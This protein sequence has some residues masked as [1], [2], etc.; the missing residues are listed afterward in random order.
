MVER[1]EGTPSL[2]TES[3][4]GIDKDAIISRAAD[5]AAEEAK[6]Q[7][8][9]S[10]GEIKGRLEDANEKIK[11]ANDLMRPFSKYERLGRKAVRK[12]G[13]NMPRTVNADKRQNRR[14]KRTIRI[15]PRTAQSAVRN[16]TNR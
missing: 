10:L 16:Y 11:S 2:D 6:D 3:L 4:E 7:A 13:R 1:E 9:N 5:A 15:Q 8:G 14:A 12:S